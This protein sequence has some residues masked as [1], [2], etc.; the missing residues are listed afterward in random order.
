VKNKSKK[1]L[2]DQISELEKQIEKVSGQKKSQVE[3]NFTNGKDQILQ[4][5]TDNVSDLIA[6]LD[7]KGRRVYNSKSYKNILG[8]P[9]ALKGTDSF[10]EIHPDDRDKIKHIFEET[11]KTGIG[12]RAEFRMI[13][14]NGDVRLIESQGNVIRGMEGEIKNV[15]VVS[16]DIT[17]REKIERALHDSEV[18]LDSILKSIPDVIYR[19]DPKGR[20]TFISNAVLRYG[21]TPESLL[22]KNILDLVHP[23]DKKKAVYRVN[24]RRTGERRTKSFEIRLLT[25]EGREVLFEDRSEPVS[26]Q[27]VFLLEAE[28]I[29][30]TDQPRSKTFLGTQ[31]IARDITERKKTEDEMTILAQALRCISESVCV[32]D[33]DNTIIFVND[34][35]LATYGYDR[36]ELLGKPISIVRGQENS[37]NQYD[38]ILPASMK[39]GWKG[40]IINRKK[41][42]TEFPIHLSTAVIYEQSGFPIAL[43][44][45]ATDITD[46]KHLETQLQQSQKLEA[47]GKLAGGVAHDFNNLLTVIQGYSE[48]LLA[49]INAND[50]I[51]EQIK[52]INHAASRAE[53]LTRQLLAFSRKQIMQPRII[54]VNKLVHDMRDMLQ[55]LIGADIEIN[56]NLGRQLGK[57]KA[58][59]GQ[60]EQVIMNL[61]V[62]AR[63]AMKKGGKL[64]IESKNTIID[65]V[66]VRNYPEAVSGPYVCLSLKDTGLG[67]DE[68]TQ[69]HIFEP[70][71]T[72]KD[73]GEGT[74]LGLATVYGI[75]KQSGGYIYVES[76]LSK[77]STFNLY[78][79][80]VDGPLDSDV[81][82]T[83]AD[84]KLT[85][86]ET[87]LVVEDQDE[88]RQLILES[89]NFYGYHVLESPH[90]GSALLT[91]EQNPGKIDLIISD[92]VMPQMNGQELVKR[93]KSLQPQMKV[94]FISGYSEEM[95]SERHTLDPDILFLQKPFTPL[96]MLRKVREVL[97]S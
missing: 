6:I 93:L 19:L 35:F 42:G 61:A 41:D 43:I 73:K 54:D 30:A 62:N 51:A 97:D 22:G 4:M 11:V 90:G 69:A 31:G 75:I 17:D 27:P 85:G 9:E 94:M 39:G 72:T 63:D 84:N 77:G 15:I 48:L 57:I 25:S 37:D 32:T 52:Q 65:E 36:E 58:D 10:R 66:F 56:I 24:E 7:L 91:C 47:I 16:R 81:K 83:V 86:N 49:K 45:V 67:M 50:P 18:R 82:A 88:V 68:E 78:F 71:F 3:N 95:F 5:I 33:L 46:R 14:E 40:E 60:I 28:G 2:L 55:R 34:A 38:E 23:D 74:G 12:Q 20:I 59:R 80:R 89:L 79:P 26:M 53:S 92:L 87:I 96:E 64:I 76:E 1:E 13:S 21:Y 44:G 8:E 29:Y 70:F